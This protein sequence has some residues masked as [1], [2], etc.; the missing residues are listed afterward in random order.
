[1][2]IA[3]FGSCLFLTIIGLILLH[4]CA[5]SPELV[6]QGLIE[7]KIERLRIG[8][9]KSEVESIFG[10]DHGSDRNR[11]IYQ[12][13]DKEFALSDRQGVGAGLLPISAGVVPTNTRAVVA[14]N[15]TS[16]G[17]VR[18]VEVIRFFDEPYINDYWFLLKDAAKNPL[19]SVAAIGES[20]GF[21]VAA[22]DKNAGTFTLED[23]ASKARLAVK[24]EG[25][26]LRV[27]S[28]NPHHRFA[29]EYRVYTKRE[30]ALTNGIANSELVQ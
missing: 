29:N 16:A 15:F 30:A 6:S 24:V 25:A 2:R 11:W 20:V 3:H 28:K 7:D 27:T 26:T 4:S 12:F 1:M 18:T 9:S 19:E 23:P 22:L 14:V 13:A 21:K 8:Q 5:T 17:M 10:A